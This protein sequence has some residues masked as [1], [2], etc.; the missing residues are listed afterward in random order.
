MSTAATKTKVD[1][2]IKGQVKSFAVNESFAGQLI[3]GPP[4]TRS[5]PVAC[6]QL[7]LLAVLASELSGKKRAELFTNLI[8]VFANDKALPASDLDIQAECKTLLTALRWSKSQTARG[9]VRFEVA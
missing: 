2:T 1:L 8:E 6:G 5:T 3:V 7:E 9:P 4:S